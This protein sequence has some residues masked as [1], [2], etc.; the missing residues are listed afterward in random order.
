MILYLQY[1]VFGLFQNCLL[2]FYY[3]AASQRPDLSCIWKMLG[4]A[5]TIL[6]V[7]DTNNFRWVILF[8]N[9]S[10]NLLSCM[11]PFPLETSYLCIGLPFS[12][13][14]SLSHCTS[15]TVTYNWPT[16][17]SYHLAYSFSLPSLCLFPLLSFTYHSPLLFYFTTLPSITLSYSLLILFLYSISLPTTNMYLSF[18]AFLLLLFSSINLIPDF[19]YH[20]LSLSLSLPHPPSPSHA[21]KG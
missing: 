1:I 5:C 11:P 12:L 6:N 16:T 21:S 17:L 3:R 20:A 7:V 15:F 13:R 8:F 19:S 10:T 14:L 18:T 9:T 4:D 2:C